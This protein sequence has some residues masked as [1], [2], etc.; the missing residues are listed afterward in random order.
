MNATE[1]LAVTQARARMAISEAAVTSAIYESARAARELPDGKLDHA[2]ERLG[3]A[4]HAA[5]ESD[6]W[7]RCAYASEQTMVD[8]MSP[9]DE[10]IESARQDTARALDAARIAERQLRELRKLL[11]NA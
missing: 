8:E 7:A 5:D 6:T 1:K 2:R 9:T 3:I 4:N 10:Q 11:S